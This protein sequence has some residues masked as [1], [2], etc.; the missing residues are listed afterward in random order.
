METEEERKKDYISRV[1]ASAGEAEVEQLAW[2]LCP[3][4]HDDFDYPR[5]PLPECRRCEW[6]RG[7]SV[8]GCRHRAQQVALAALGR[9]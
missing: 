5:L 7:Q 2:R 6:I 1:S 9:S 4:I 8:R 3:F